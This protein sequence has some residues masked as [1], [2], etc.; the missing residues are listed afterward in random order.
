LEA[1]R[2]LPT[3]HAVLISRLPDRV[4]QEELIARAP[5]LTQRQVRVA[6]E[7]LRMEP[8]LRLEAALASGRPSE[9]PAFDDR[10]IVLGDLCHQ[11]MRLLLILRDDA[12][13]RRKATPALADLRRALD[14]MLEA[15]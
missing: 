7:R 15:A 3:D 5:E 2:N 6:V 13:R 4:Q 10:L 11:L 9:K 12:E 1:V 14:E 8:Q